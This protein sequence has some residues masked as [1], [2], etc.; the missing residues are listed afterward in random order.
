[1]TY[2]WVSMGAACRKG[3]PHSERQRLIRESDPRRSSGGSD[4]FP[5]GI[6]GPS[7]HIGSRS[8]SRGSTRFCISFVLHRGGTQIFSADWAVSTIRGTR[9]QPKCRRRGIQ[10]GD[11][12]LREESFPSLRQG[13]A[14]PTRVCLLTHCISSA[15]A[16]V[17]VANLRALSFGNLFSVAAF[18]RQKPH[19][20]T[21][22]R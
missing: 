15:S 7:L 13:L 4:R 10:S 16:S 22:H 20:R 8:D 1:M 18:R 21:W 2:T 9:L 19:C 6:V 11:C 12:C 14:P 5:T 3:D 17:T